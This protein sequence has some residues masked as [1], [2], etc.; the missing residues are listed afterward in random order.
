MPVNEPSYGIWA[1][2]ACVVLGGAGCGDGGAPRSTAGFGVGLG[3]SDWP[4]PGSETGSVGT[5]GDSSGAGGPGDDD[6]TTAGGAS[7]DSPEPGTTG[8]DRPPAAPMHFSLIF[9]ETVQACGGCGI[10]FDWQGVDEDK[11]GLEVSWS[12]DGVQ[13]T[14]VYRHGVGPDG[15]AFGY[16]ILPEGA[17]QPE[18]NR[19]SML[20]K[21]A[22]ARNGLFYADLSQIPVEAT[23]DAATV[24]LHIHTGEGLAYG[25]HQSV[26]EVWSCPTPWNW[27]EVD[28]AQA[29]AGVPWGQPGGDFGSFIR[30]IR[31]WDDMHAV[32][33]DKSNPDAE[34]DFTAHVQ[35]LQADR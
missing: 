17:G 15:D 8:E 22:P 16:F 4:E 32:G 3:T 21:Q 30:E 33:Y 10:W 6:S 12:L 31:A 5:T 2:V 35:Q 7:T 25:D 34:F 28:W 26:L 27:D 29:S 19:H 18:Q 20:V 1:L 14:S 23:I 13:T 11:P 24:Q 9:R